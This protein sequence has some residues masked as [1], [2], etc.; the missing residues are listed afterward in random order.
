MLANQIIAIF[1]VFC[2]SS[3]RPS[4]PALVRL[5]TFDLRW[6]STGLVTLSVP[7]TPAMSTGFKVL[8]YAVVEGEVI[9]DSAQYEATPCL[10]NPVSVRWSPENVRPKRQTQLSIS[11]AP[12]SLCGIGRT[13]PELAPP[14][15]MARWNG[16]VPDLL[17]ATFGFRSSDVWEPWYIYLVLAN[18]HGIFYFTIWHVYWFLNRS[19]SLNVYH[20]VPIPSCLRVMGYWTSIIFRVS[21]KV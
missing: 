21:G 3:F 6:L 12:G 18:R 1:S 17:V 16:A 2:T 15:A 7:V 20:Q 11:A 4:E 10:E 19:K 14:A 13:G 9:A 5:A 8:V